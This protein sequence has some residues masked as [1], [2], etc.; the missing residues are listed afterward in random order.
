MK[1]FLYAGV[2]VV[3]VL[4][5]ALISGNSFGQAK[6]VG[7]GDIKYTNTKGLGPVTFSHA[8]HDGKGLKCTECHT[9]IYKMKKG[10]AKVDMATLNKGESCGSCHNGQK[11]F[12]SKAPNDCSR[13]HIKG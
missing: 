5:V 7:G 1:R 9:K 6:K 2:L 4:A 11:V 13:C 3:A 10:E 12:S 8:F